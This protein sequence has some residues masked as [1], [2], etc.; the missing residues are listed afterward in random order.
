MVFTAGSHW[1]ARDTSPWNLAKSTLAE[2]TQGPRAN[3]GPGA[4]SKPIAPAAPAAPAAPVALQRPAVGLPAG[5]AV[6]PSE[7]LGPPPAAEQ[8]DRVGFGLPGAG[9]QPT[10]PCGVCGVRSPVDSMVSPPCDHFFCKP[11]IQ[12]HLDDSTTCPQCND[13]LPAPLI[14]AVCGVNLPARDPAARPAPVAPVAPRAPVAD[15]PMEPVK[16]CK[17]CLEASAMSSLVSPPCDDFFCRPCIRKHLMLLEKEVE[18]AKCPV[19]GERAGGSEWLGACASVI[20]REEQACTRASRGGCVTK[21]TVAARVGLD[22]W[23]SAR[24][25]FRSLSSP[26]FWAQIFLH[27]R[28]E[29][30]CLV[31][32]LL[33]CVQ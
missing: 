7:V 21:P 4:A 32:L 8:K 19:P 22:P 18:D 28:S 24:S 31:S 29:S 10:R 5:G 11:C 1:T 13:E 23:R 14:E 3:A 12:A 9:L 2:V 15:S 16:E 17:V 33:L 30:G 20:I 26:P 25:S 6:P 27:G